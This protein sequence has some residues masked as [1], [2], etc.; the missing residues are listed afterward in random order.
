MGYNQEGSRIDTICSVAT[1]IGKSGIGIVRVSGPQTKHIGKKILKKLPATR[2]AELLNFY[3][4]TGE[5]IDR[6]IAIFFAGPNSFTGEDILEL[7]AHGGPVLLDMLMQE[8]LHLGA[9]QAF[10]GEFSQ[11]AFLNGKIDLT[12]AEAIA[13]M[14]DATSSQAV[15]SASKSLQ[16]E[17]SHK[18]SKLVAEL[19]KLRTFVEAAIDFPE[20]E[21]DFIKNSA[22]NRRL[23]DLL[24]SIE[25][26]L[27]KAKTGNLLREGLTLVIAGR[28]NAG[29][30]SLLNCLAGKQS[31]I[32]TDIPGTTR[33]V[34]KEYIQVDGIPLHIMDTAG[35][36][37]TRDKIEREGIK[38]T[39]GEIDTAD[40]LLLVV[41][42][43]TGLTHEDKKI[44]KKIKDK[45]P[46]II[47]LNKIDQTGKKISQDK[48]LGVDALTICA[49]KCIGIDLLKNKLKE[50]MGYTEASEG[51]F[52]ARRRHLTALNT[53]RKNI[54][55]SLKQL[56]DF[57]AGE[58]LA[59]DLREAQ[60]NLAQITGGITSDELLGKI[61]DNFCIG[62]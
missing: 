42:D 13:D 7:Q 33:D 29:K 20:E 4:H 36:R 16:G 43:N 9:R 46:I 58:L 10:P 47:L 56:Q 50:I 34:L 45:L 44:I 18:I 15:R 27:A 37:P 5:V 54:A 52:M 25:E 28:P 59:E 30:S 49:K 57:N 14:I 11:R 24:L 60:N 31:A 62:K 8:L 26:I 39:W 53:A 2:Q 3:E 22:V 23:Q 17:F 61:F 12:Q 32:V 38:R 35:L 40:G 6:G 51:V 19:T 1:A 21:I 41:D 55:N 48:I